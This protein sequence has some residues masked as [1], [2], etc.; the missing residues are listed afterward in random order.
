M[1][2]NLTTKLKSYDPEERE[3]A[4]VAL[5]EMDN[6]LAV[7]VL[8]RAIGDPHPLVFFAVME[9][10]EK[11]KEHI[12]DKQF[13]QLLDGLDSDNQ[14]TRHHTTSILGVIGNLKAVAPLLEIVTDPDLDLNHHLLIIEM[15]DMQLVVRAQ[16]IAMR[17]DGKKMQE[18]HF[19]SPLAN[20]S[21]EEKEMADFYINVLYS[22]QEL[23]KN[24]PFPEVKSKALKAEAPG[25]PKTDYGRLIIGA[26]QE[27]LKKTQEMKTGAKAFR[28]TQ[29]RDPKRRLPH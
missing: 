5:G 12:T 14:G 11:L 28:R 18:S 20:P 17:L 27:H 15:A 24:S 26:A 9:S 29:K 25:I 16:E 4:A 2:I 3:K 6:P 13:L 8:I 1:V 22:L 10:L 21:K 19:P 7:D 23:L